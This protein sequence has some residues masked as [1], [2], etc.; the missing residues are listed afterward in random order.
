MGWFPRPAPLRVALECRASVRRRAV[1]TQEDAVAAERLRKAAG[2]VRGMTARDYSAIITAKGNVFRELDAVRRE[3]GRVGP[4]AYHEAVKLMAAWNADALVEDL[5]TTMGR[6][7]VAVRDE[8]YLVALRCYARRDKS[9]VRFS[10]LL[11]A[12]PQRVSSM[13]RVWAWAMLSSKTDLREA[14]AR[15]G[16][17]VDAHCHAALLRVLPLAEAGT[18]YAQLTAQGTR[19][20]FASVYLW[21]L[22]E[23]GRGEE[24]EALLSASGLHTEHCLKLRILAGCARGDWPAV[25]AALRDGDKLPDGMTDVY[26]FT[27]VLRLLTEK[28]RAAHGGGGWVELSELWFQRAAATGIRSLAQHRLLLDLYTALGLRTKAEALEAE[29]R[30]EALP[31]RGEAMRHLHLN[32][33]HERPGMA[34]LPRR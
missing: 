28:A 33:K 21:R 34:G 16:V 22:A 12:V 9:A 23:A 32:R 3:N 18:L 13:P 7:G 5:L 11:P 17:A 25:K 24:L 15:A 19:P 30:R 27:V 29:M 1:L 8:T 4:G 6:E 20:L 26:V 31:V 10:A 14:M 2:R